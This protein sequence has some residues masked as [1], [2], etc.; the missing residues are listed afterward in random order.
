MQ[1]AIRRIHSEYLGQKE[2]PKNM[3]EFEIREFFTLSSADKRAIRIRRVDPQQSPIDNALL[4][5]L[6]L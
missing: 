6:G 4:A 1:S 5:R 2:F 3:R